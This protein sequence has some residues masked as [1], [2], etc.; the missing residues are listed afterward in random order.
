M[1][2]EKTFVDDIDRSMYDFRYEDKDAYKLEEGLTPAIVAQISEEKNDPEWMKEFRLKSL[3]IY[4]QIP[5]PEWGPSIEGLNMDNIVTYVRPKD[6]KMVADWDEVPTDIKSTFEKLG[7]PQAERESLAG[8]GAQ[9]DSELVYHNVKEEV[10]AQGV[11][12]TDLESA[13]HGPYADMIKEH[14]MKLVP[15][16][17]HKFAALHGAVWSGGSFVYVPPGV[18]VEI[19]LQSYFRLNAPGAGQFEHTLII[20]DEGAYLH[21]IEGCS[22]PKYNVANLHAGCVELFVG[23]NATLRYSTIENWSKNMYNLNTKRARVE[24]GGK[25][26]WISGSFGSH[27]SYLYPMSVLAGKGARSEFTSVTF[28]GKGQNLDTGCKVVHNAPET[29]SVVNTRSISKDGG[30]STFRSAVVV[31]NKAKGSKSSVSCASLMLDDISQSDTVPA[32]DI[33]T[34][35]ADV[36]HEAKIGRISDE[37]IFYLMSRGMSEEDARA[38]V[39]SGFADNVGKEL[40]LEYA[41]EMNNLIRL[42]MKGSIG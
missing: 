13:L 7:I 27:V 11:V 40:P 41:V 12:Y 23:K 14:F 31:A 1:S 9:Y 35:D 20:V 34:A 18:S 32:M 33:R 8:V 29:S 5:V 2:K 21:F 10:A 17:D 26:E 22:A 28:A 16:T 19:P 25:V 6:N 15:P 30:I 39:V 37:T 36:G 4:D 24:E 38:L 3:G 42:E